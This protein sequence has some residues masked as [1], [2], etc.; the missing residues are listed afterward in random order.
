[1]SNINRIFEV[2]PLISD[3]IQALDE[4]LKSKSFFKEKQFHKLFE[5]HP[6]LLN[7][8]G[9]IKFIS[10]FSVR[11]L[12]FDEEISYYK[13]RIDILA[14]RKGAISSNNLFVDIIELKQPS[15]KI[16]DGKDKRRPSGTVSK[17]I[18]QLYTYQE[19]LLRNVDVK[20]ELRSINMSIINP[21]KTLIC[22]RDEEFSDNPND[23]EF[24]K[25]HLL[26]RGV[27][28]YTVDAILR[29]A[30]KFKDEQI[31]RFLLSFNLPRDHVE[32][33]LT[34]AGNWKLSLVEEN[35]IAQPFDKISNISPLHFSKGHGLTYVPRGY[36]MQID[37][38]KVPVCPHCGSENLSS[39]T[40][41]KLPS[42]DIIG[43]EADP[44]IVC[45]DCGEVDISC[46]FRWPKD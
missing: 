12:T 14:A 27:R 6:A 18:S 9:Y 21:Q 25:T 5:E 43:D 19:D 37:E 46:R 3:D 36:Q 10:E 29:L 44:C 40:Y 8:L 31:G 35:I 4:F 38:G 39:E 23:Y 24:I 1:M 17:A 45:D 16:A 34:R 26:D 11:K 30:E 41:Y 13:D 15:I 33:L 20:E 28:H 42:G 22:G 32:L 2:P 7:V